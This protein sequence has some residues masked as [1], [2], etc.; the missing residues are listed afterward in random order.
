MDVPPIAY[1]GLEP[2]EGLKEVVINPID[3]ALQWIGFENKATHERLH[4][5]GFNLSFVEIQSMR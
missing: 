4:I 1:L 3:L 5:E 2:V